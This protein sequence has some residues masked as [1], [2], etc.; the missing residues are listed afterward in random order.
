MKSIKNKKINYFFKYG[1]YFI[2]DN[3]LTLFNDFYSINIKSEQIDIFKLSLLAKRQTSINI[4]NFLNLTKEQFNLINNYS[5]L[6]KKLFKFYNNSVIMK[7]IIKQCPFCFSDNKIHNYKCATLRKENFEYNLSITL[8]SILNKEL[9]LKLK[10]IK[11]SKILK[12]DII[13]K[14]LK[15]FKALGIPLNKNNFYFEHYKNKIDI[16]VK[17]EFLSFSINQKLFS[18]YFKNNK[19]L[20]NIVPQDYSYIQIEYNLFHINKIIKFSNIE[21]H[22][23]FSKILA[24]KLE[25]LIHYSL[26]LKSKYFSSLLNIFKKQNININL[27]N[28]HIKCY[29][30][31]IYEISYKNQPFFYI[32]INENNYGTINNVPAIY[33]NYSYNN[34]DFNETLSYTQ[35]SLLLL[36]NFCINNGWLT[37]QN[38]LLSNNKYISQITLYNISDHAIVYNVIIN[39]ITHFL[40]FHYNAKDIENYSLSINLSDFQ[41]IDDLLNNYKKHIK[42]NKYSKVC[43]LSNTEKQIN[44]YKLQ[45]QKKRINYII[46]KDNKKRKHAIRNEFKKQDFIIIS[47]EN[48]KYQQKN[49]IL[50]PNYIKTQFLLYHDKLFYIRFLQYSFN[51]NKVQDNST[52][53]LIN[54]DFNINF[55]KLKTRKNNI[56]LLP[57]YLKD[58]SIEDNFALFIFDIFT[59]IVYKKININDDIYIYNFIKINDSLP[60][61]ILFFD[62]FYNVNYN[63]KLC[64]KHYFFLDKKFNK[65]YLFEKYQDLFFAYLIYTGHY[66]ELSEKTNSYIKKLIRFKFLKE[67]DIKKCLK[68]IK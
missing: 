6:E 20:F 40:Y 59:K 50:I 57:R 30:T 21:E 31:R 45:S 13:T 22:I 33:I 10:Q 25:K 5:I 16:Y 36:V 52:T 49:K 58:I 38:Y 67:E 46:Y 61:Y 35:N 4:L 11:E 53:I 62:Q 28:V 56:L 42:Y 17:I 7:N 19:D 60:D 65:T 1:K 3:F 8:N 37:G 41:N 66:Y 2:E 55:L 68:A 24:G 9:F 15:F 51:I 12:L 44:Q 14:I 34:F 48:D 63:E 47:N 18:V 54:N 26:I 43:A 32:V 23:S 64:I 29:K 27:D 39:D